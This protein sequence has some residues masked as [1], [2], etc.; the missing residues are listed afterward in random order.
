MF[1]AWTM[2]CTHLAEDHA[3]HPVRHVLVE[4]VAVVLHIVRQDVGLRPDQQDVP[5]ERRV[6]P[7]GRERRDCVVD[8]QEPHPVLVRVPAAVMRA[9]YEDLAGGGRAGQ[10]RVLAVVVP[11]ANLADQDLVAQLQL[12][13]RDEHLGTA[14]ATSCSFPGKYIIDRLAQVSPPPLGSSGGGGY[15]PRCDRRPDV[16]CCCVGGG[17]GWPLL[18]GRKSDTSAIIS[19][20]ESIAADGRCVP[21]SVHAKLHIRLCHLHLLI[22]RYG[23]F[24]RIIMD[25]VGWHSESRM[26]TISGVAA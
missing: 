14:A 16:L 7:A 21:V 13:R 4:D 10:R 3:V 1:A 9:V 19:D 6:Q 22:A 5:V 26:C 12:E 25:H 8:V 20:T 2:L 23:G 17:S 24:L 11:D 18:A 15:I